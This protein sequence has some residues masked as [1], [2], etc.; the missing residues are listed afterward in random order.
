MNPLF[1]SHFLGALVFTGAASLL[2][3]GDG[4]RSVLP[5]VGT[6]FVLYMV[7]FVTTIAVN[8]PLNDSIKAAGD[9]GVIRDLRAVRT[10]FDEGKWARWN[11]MR[12]I[13]TTAALGCLTWALVAY[14]RL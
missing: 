14:G 5:W 13:L 11:L 4:D 12:A 6:A 2:H 7:V 1:L 9:P 8:V 3:L 10:R